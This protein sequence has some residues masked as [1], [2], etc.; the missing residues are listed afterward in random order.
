M[1]IKNKT[2]F[3]DHNILEV[4]NLRKTITTQGKGVIAITSIEAN[5]AVVG[6]VA[7][8]AKAI[9][10][11]K[12]SVLLIDCD[13]SA[14]KVHEWFDIPNSEGFLDCI[15]SKNPDKH[16]N[17]VQI[18]L[19]E[20]DG[21]LVIPCEFAPEKCEVIV[22]HSALSLILGYKNEFDFVVLLL[23]PLKTSFEASELMSVAD[24]TYV[25]F[26]PLQNTR[27]EVAKTLQTL[28]FSN[29][30]INGWIAIDRKFKKYDYFTRFF[31]K[32]AK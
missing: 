1:T 13:A 26:T 7:E 10:I 30:K 16:H 12:T 11:Q 6:V 28:A 14:P 18:K 20:N 29:N 31:K 21:I 17:M 9:Q 19:G 23:P 32:Q 15:S 5:D 3:A 24:Q 22:S 27:F 4:R 8:L 2:L 25:C